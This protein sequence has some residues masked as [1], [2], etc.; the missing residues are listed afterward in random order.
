MNSGSCECGCGKVVNSG[1]RFIS[2]HNSRL[3]PKKPEPIPELCECG[4]EQLAAPGCKFISGHNSRLMTEEQKDRLRTRNI[5]RKHT[6]E[7]LEKMSKAKQG[8]NN[9][10]FGKYGE[11]HP[12]YGMKRSEETRRKIGEKSKLK[13]ISAPTRLLMSKASKGKPKSLE[14]RMNIGKALEGRVFSEEWRRKNSEAHKGKCIGELNP[15]WKGGFVPEPYG[16]EFNAIL[17]ATIRERDG[18]RCQNPYCFGESKRLVVHHIDYDKKNCE[19]FN[20]ITL[21]NSCNSRANSNRP[22]WEL[23][24]SS[25]INALYPNV[26]NL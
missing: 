11:A 10:M 22:Y 8:L 15:N 14:H 26:V 4:C 9:W 16:V 20:L 13:V 3:R 1:K 12:Q 6:P 2:G 23:I 19:E 7:S 18:Y 17:R 25:L 24:Y 21:C 5:G